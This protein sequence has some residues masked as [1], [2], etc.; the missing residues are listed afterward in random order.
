MILFVPALLIA[1][2]VL[3]WIAWLAVGPRSVSPSA[4]RFFFQER[5][6]SPGPSTSDESP[7]ASEMDSEYQKH[8]QK[9]LEEPHLPL[10][11]VSG[12]SHPTGSWL[13]PRGPAQH[14]RGRE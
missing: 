4:R 14:E 7:A 9:R 1:I 11:S 2:V 12:A 3:A 13:A 8:V 10:G 5:I 6:P